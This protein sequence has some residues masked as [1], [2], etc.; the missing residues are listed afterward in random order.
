MGRYYKHTLRETNPKCGGNRMVRESFC[1][2][3]SDVGETEGK[4]KL[5][6]NQ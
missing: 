4:E 3:R 1:C 6:E 5:H 2:E